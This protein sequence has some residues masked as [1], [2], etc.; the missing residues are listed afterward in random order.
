[1]RDVSA[2]MSRIFFADLSLNEQCR[3][4]ASFADTIS[5]DKQLNFSSLQSWHS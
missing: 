5:A 3:L 2:D 1:M 4:T